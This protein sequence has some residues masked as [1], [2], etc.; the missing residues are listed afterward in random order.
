MLLILVMICLFELFLNEG[1][2]ETGEKVYRKD[3]HDVINVVL[4]TRISAPNTDML[5]Q[6]K[7]GFPL[8]R[9]CLRMLTYVKTKNGRN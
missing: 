1:T 3:F 9:L 4:N 2:R 5:S 6:C 7:G 8:S